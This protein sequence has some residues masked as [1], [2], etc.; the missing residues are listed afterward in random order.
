[1]GGG[2]HTETCTDGAVSD[3]GH[4][5]LGD[6]GTESLGA[7]E[8]Q[9]TGP[10]RCTGKVGMGNGLSADQGHLYTRAA[11]IKSRGRSG[12]KALPSGSCRKNCPAE[13]GSALPERGQGCRA[14]GTGCLGAAG[15][16]RA[17]LAPR[18]CCQFPLRASSLCLRSPHT[19]SLG[20]KRS[21]HLTGNTLSLAVPGRN[22]L[23]Q[24][25]RQPRA[26][27][28]PALPSCYPDADS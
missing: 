24:G 12:G 27:H 2:C 21:P 20:L 9:R 8:P 6:S 19:G 28:G 4:C 26:H 16:E 15:K 25:P 22:Y 14:P 13:R 17:G 11:L 7:G 3:Q 23:P 10:Q 5:S 1:M 18:G